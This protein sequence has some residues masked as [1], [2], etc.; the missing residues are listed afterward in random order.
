MYHNPRCHSAYRNQ[1]E[2]RKA[3]KAEREV[4][5]FFLFNP[6]GWVVG[7]FIIWLINS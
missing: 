2:Q 5:K 7:G 4:I 1:T 3:E 6:V